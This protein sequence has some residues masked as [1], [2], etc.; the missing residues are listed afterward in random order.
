MTKF[1]VFREKRQKHWLNLLQGW[2]SY[3]PRIISIF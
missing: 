1:L 2:I 3:K